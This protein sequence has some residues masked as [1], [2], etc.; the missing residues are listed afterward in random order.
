M[1]TIVDRMPF[2]LPATAVASGELAAVH[3]K[4]A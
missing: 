4:V 2:A 1:P 3:Q